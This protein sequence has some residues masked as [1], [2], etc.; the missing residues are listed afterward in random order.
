M[1]ASEPPRRPSKCSILVA[2]DMVLD[3]AP[4]K[5]QRAYKSDPVA[6]SKDRSIRA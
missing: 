1:T 6:I 3:T 2:L 5:A 4:A